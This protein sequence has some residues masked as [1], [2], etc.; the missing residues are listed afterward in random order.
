MIGR[1]QDPEGERRSGGTGP[2]LLAAALV[3]TAACGSGTRG[4]SQPLALAN[5]DRLAASVLDTVPRRIGSCR[6]ARL[7]R[8]DTLTLRMDVPHDEQLALVD[9]DGHW[10][11]LVHPFPF[12]PTLAEP[13][14]F[15][16][17][18]VFRLVAGETR[19]KVMVEGRDEP[20]PVLALPGRHRVLVLSH[21]GTDAREPVFECTVVV[22]EGA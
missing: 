18:S 4:G 2:R 14:A 8:G 7:A 15:A 10:I 6:P 11:Y 22:E 17:D 3:L 16:V 1:D 12:A 20:E 13:P 5:A 9:P 21:L 19:A